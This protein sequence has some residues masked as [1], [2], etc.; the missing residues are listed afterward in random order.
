MSFVRRRWPCIKIS[1]YLI[2]SIR[3]WWYGKYFPAIFR[4][5]FYSVVKSLSK[6]CTAVHWPTCWLCPFG[7]LLIAPS[8]EFFSVCFARYPVRLVII[9]LPLFVGA[10]LWD[11]AE[12]IWSNLTTINFN[13]LTCLAVWKWMSEM[14]DN[15]SIAPKFLNWCRGKGIKELNFCS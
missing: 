9:L 14:M 12:I 13:K 10:Y 8:N 6:F 4:S 2:I 5:P 3:L 7:V 1:L 15:F 11:A